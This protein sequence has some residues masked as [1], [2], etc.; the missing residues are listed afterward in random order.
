MYEL[1]PFDVGEASFGLMGAAPERPGNDTGG[2][3]APLCEFDGDAADFLDRPADQEGLVR[4]R[5]G[6]P[7]FGSTTALAC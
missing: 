3:D 2:L 7:F 6:S 4:R 1:C 5:G